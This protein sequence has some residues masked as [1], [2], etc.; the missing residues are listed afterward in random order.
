M[1]LPSLQSTAT[2]FVVGAVL[3]VPLTWY[4]TSEYKE[5]RHSAF[6]NQQRAQAAT[7]LQT[8]TMKVV[9]A[10]RRATKFKDELEIQ[11]AK[12]LEQI[13]AILANNKRLA[14]KLGGLRDPWK[15][16]DCGGANMSRI[17]D[18]P[19]SNPTIAAGSHISDEASGFLSAEAS[20]FLLELAAEADRAAIYAQTCHKF[21]IDSLKSTKEKDHGR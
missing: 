1:I 2:A 7:V 21:A 3:S 4:V 13:N 9:E 8:Q 10:E 11:N 19:G 17:T 16:A 14:A 18:P 6:I 5:A 15:T 20:E 12:S